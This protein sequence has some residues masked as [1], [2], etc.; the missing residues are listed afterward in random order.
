MTEHMVPPEKTCAIAIVEDEPGTRDRIARV[1]SSDPTLQLVRAASAG[2]EIIDFLARSVAVD[3]LLVDLGLPDL[4]GL[5]VI[6]RC[7]VMRPQCSIMVLTMFGDEDHMVQAFEA[8][9]TGYLLKDGTEADLSKHVRELRAGGSPISPSI[10]R[11]L[12]LRW[13]TGEHNVARSPSASPPTHAGVV[14][15]LSDKELQILDLT[16]RGFTYPEVASRMQ[17]ATRTVQSHIRNIYA[18]LDVHNK[19]EA[20][21]EARHLG[22]LS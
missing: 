18:K 10:A 22:L 1:I 3:V 11:Q 9:A 5:E 8:G 19:A 12:L 17:I 20:V 6:R 7:R 14:E 16:S 4:P 2:R 21:Y 15:A 13:Q